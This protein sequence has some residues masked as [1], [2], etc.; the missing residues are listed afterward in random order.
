M[1]ALLS[2]IFNLVSSIF[3]TVSGGLGVGAASTSVLLSGV[4]TL[5]GPAALGLAEAAF[6]STLIVDTESNR[7]AFGKRWTDALSTVADGLNQLSSSGE[8]RRRVACCG[9]LQ[10]PRR[11]GV[12]GGHVHVL[13]LLCAQATCARSCKACAS[14]SRRRRT[15]WAPRCPS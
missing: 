12:H 5:T 1:L 15:S 14:S 4:A 13:V 9:L 8:R 10:G 6:A 2:A 3:Y 7:D 11:L